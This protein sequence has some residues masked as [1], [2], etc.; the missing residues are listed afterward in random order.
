MPPPAGE[1]GNA[2][3]EGYED[4]YSQNNLLGDATALD[5]AGEDTAGGLRSWATGAL[6]VHDWM[7]GGGT[8]GGT[9]GEMTYEELCR[10]EL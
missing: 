9:D 7:G 4:D 5:D 2:G 10:W 1:F 8:G 6:G 3:Y